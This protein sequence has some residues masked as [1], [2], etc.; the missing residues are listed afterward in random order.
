MVYR[1]FREDWH[2]NMKYQF[3]GHKC[4]DNDVFDF[5]PEERNVELKHIPTDAVPVDIATAQHGW[6]MSFSHT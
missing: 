2:S 6:I 1:P 5:D 4:D 3:D